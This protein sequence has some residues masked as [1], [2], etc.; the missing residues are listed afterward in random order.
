MPVTA[1]KTVV[2]PAPFGPMTEK[3]CPVSTWRSTLLT[4]VRPPNRTVSCRTSRRG[5]PWLPVAQFSPSSPKRKRG[6]GDYLHSPPRRQ[7]SFRSESHHQDQRQSKHR[8]SPAAKSQVLR[9]GM[10]KRPL[11]VRISNRRQDLVDS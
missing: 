4:A 5:T 8:Q 6:G 11:I 7:Y 1:L 10:T 3:I 9:A 2:L